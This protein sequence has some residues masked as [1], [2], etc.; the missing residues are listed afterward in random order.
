MNNLAPLIL[1]AVLGLLAG[2]GQGVVTYL[3]GLPVP[4]VDQL[5]QPF[6]SNQTLRD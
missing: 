5:S 4:L 1:P 3:A 6:E 2:M